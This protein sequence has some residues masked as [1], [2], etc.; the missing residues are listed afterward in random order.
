MTGQMPFGNIT[1][2]AVEKSFARDEELLRV[3]DA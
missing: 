2:P 3:F 1:A